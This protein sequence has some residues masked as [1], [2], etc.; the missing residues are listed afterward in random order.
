M[1]Q[2]SMTTKHRGGTL[3]SESFAPLFVAATTPD[4]APGR[5]CDAGSRQQPGEGHRGHHQQRLSGPVG[6]LAHLPEG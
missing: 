6:R 1:T 3:R 2:S 5:R 4:G